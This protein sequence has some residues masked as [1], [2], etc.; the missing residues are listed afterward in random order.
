MAPQLIRTRSPKGVAQVNP[1]RPARWL[2]AVVVLTA[3]A[4]FGAT[5]SP[6]ASVAA[7]GS[8]SGGWSPL[9]HGTKR[10]AP[11]LT[12]KVETFTSVGKTLYVGGDFLD[13]GG[14]AAADHIAAWNGKAWSALGG[15]LGNSPSAVYAIAVDPV[16]G[17]VF[18]AGSFQDAG[19]DLR[20][21]AIARFNG[22]SWTSLSSVGLNGTAFALAI[23]G[24]TLY[25]G[26]GF[27]EAA[28]IAEAD[29]VAS[30]GI[31]SGVWSAITNGSND[32][33][34][35]VC[36]LVPD[37]GSG[38]Y[39]GGSFID[40]DGIAAADYAAHYLGAT[41]WSPIGAS[42]PLNGRVRA[43]AV[44]GSNVYVG[45]DFINA[46]GNTNADKVAL[47]AGSDWLPLGSTSAFGDGGN[48]IYALAVDED[49]VFAAGYFNNAGGSAKIDGIGAFSAG[50]WRNVGTNGTGHDGPVPVNTLMTSLRV[51]GD[52]LFLGGL[53]PAIG[54]STRNAYAS[55]FRLRQPDGQISVG[56]GALVGNGVYNSTGAR[57]TRHQTVHRS[58]TGTFRIKIANDGFSADTITLKGPGSTSGFKVTYLSGSTNI[59]AQVVAGTY[60]LGS[61][62]AGASRTIKLEVTVTSGAT[63]GATRTVLVS[64]KSTGA[65]TPKDTVKATVTVR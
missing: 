25:V 6:L 24:R 62:E 40:A 64:S 36:C 18:A 5:T 17:D 58:K 51:V 37:G 44:S 43:I 65:G 34:G 29:S 23:V 63:I 11:A 20:A 2:G 31:D 7:R 10:K 8:G 4:V 50:A 55:S 16:T 21:D 30:Y 52:Q 47:N 59:T 33:G 19:G 35:T 13:A 26:G 56:S 22:T 3:F 39:V 42:T 9:G 32:I 15:G 48:A 54:G 1:T 27:S 49:T 41:S 38:L 12:G 53:A 60:S 45:G 61:M 46:G 14:L 57:Q 28:G